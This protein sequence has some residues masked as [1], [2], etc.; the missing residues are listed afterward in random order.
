[1][2]LARCD[3]SRGESETSAPD[4]RRSV[5]ITVARA[6]TRLTSAF[7]AEKAIPQDRKL[8][9]RRLGDAAL[10]TDHRCR[11]QIR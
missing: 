8:K 1:V 2:A 7:T 5:S 3:R 9:D 11:E 6:A 10:G 4:E